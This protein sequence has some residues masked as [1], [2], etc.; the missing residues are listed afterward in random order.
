[1]KSGTSNSRSDISISKSEVSGNYG[2]VLAA[3]RYLDNFMRNSNIQ[4]RANPSIVYN[5][6]SSMQKSKE[7]SGV[8]IQTSK[9]D[10]KHSIVK[11]LPNEEILVEIT[12]E[13]EYTVNT[14]RNNKT[15]NKHDSIIKKGPESVDK[16][17]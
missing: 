3:P 12:K 11:N 2:K 13:E 8:K 7:N 5:E 17:K 10:L 15:Q 6:A 1:M 16:E 14:L 9:P 4:P